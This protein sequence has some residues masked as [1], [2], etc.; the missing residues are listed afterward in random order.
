MAR[1]KP[2]SGHDP[3]RCAEFE[4]AAAVS[5]PLCCG[6]HPSGPVSLGLVLWLQTPSPHTST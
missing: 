2:A 6:R 5:V 3:A 1:G 4:S